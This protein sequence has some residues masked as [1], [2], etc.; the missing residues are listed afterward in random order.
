MKIDEKEFKKAVLDDFM[1]KIAEI[2]KSYTK[3]DAI[4]I[5]WLEKK[6]DEYLDDG[7]NTSGTAL[8]YIIDEWR[9]ENDRS[10]MDQAFR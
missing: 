7:Y 8:R 2:K 4:P 10:Q 5:D 1:E 6:I 9:R 3:T